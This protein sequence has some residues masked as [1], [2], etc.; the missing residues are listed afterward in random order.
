M[1]DENKKSTPK[2][3]AEEIELSNQDLEQVAG[4]AG[5]TT[6]TTSTTTNK[7]KA[8]DKMYETGA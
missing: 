4:G 8:T 1:S 2:Q 6:T 5:T 3:P 7:A